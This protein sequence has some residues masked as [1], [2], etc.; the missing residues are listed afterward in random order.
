VSAEH[1]RVLVADDEASIRFVLCEALTEAGHE[2][3]RCHGDD[4][5]PFPCAALVEGRRCPLESGPVDVVL[6]AHA[7]PSRLPSRYED[8]VVCGLRSAIPLVVAGSSVHPYWR[9]VTVEIGRDDDVVAACESAACVTAERRAEID[10][11]I[12]AARSVLA[13]SGIDPESTKAVV[14]RRGERVHVLLELP[15]R[16]PGLHQAIVDRVAAAV[17]GVDATIETVDV[18]IA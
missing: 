1:A 17:R 14:H 13:G 7:H 18:A 10:A 12:D 2:V 11:A 16:P 15:A 3:V 6:D 5:P 9:W 4:E 8:G